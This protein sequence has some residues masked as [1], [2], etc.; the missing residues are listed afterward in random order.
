[1]K[2]VPPVRVDFENIDQ[3]ILALPFPTRNYGGMLA[4]KTHVLFLL[5]GP[6]VDDG[7]TDGRQIVHKFDLCTLKTEKVLDDIGN[8][9]V[10]A[11]AQKVLYEQL[12]ERKPEA[13]GNG[14]RPH[15]AWFIKSIESLGK[16][17]SGKSESGGE[18]KVASMEVAVDPRA[19]WKQMY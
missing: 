14:E 19:E 16:P 18:L 12:P 13:G 17:D 1:S 6:A 15:G 9:F 7:T 11:N 4:G 10:S 5:E 3:R 8:F 2:E